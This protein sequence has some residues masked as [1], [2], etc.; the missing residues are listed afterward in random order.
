MFYM[1]ESNRYDW[2]K[3]KT[4]K[5]KDTVYSDSRFHSLAPV[6]DQT[7]WSKVKTT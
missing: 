5:I 6:F 4:E 3:A 1:P 2:S 7:I